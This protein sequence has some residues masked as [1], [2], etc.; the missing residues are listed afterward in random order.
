MGGISQED[1][2]RL[3]DIGAQQL[4]DLLKPDAGILARVAD[5]A[6]E[7]LTH[8]AMSPIQQA[9]KDAGIGRFA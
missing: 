2:N 5:R 9:L 6:A 8:I 1:L 4:T 3:I 7:G